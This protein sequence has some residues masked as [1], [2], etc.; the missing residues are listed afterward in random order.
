MIGIYSIYSKSQNKY[1]IGK[2]VD[3]HARIQKHLND[4]KLGKHHSPYLQNVYNKYGP[5]DLHFNVIEECSL[6]FLSEKEKKY[7]QSYD[8]FKN[9]FNCT[10]GGEGTLGRVF[11]EETRRKLSENVRGE[12]NSQY[13]HW[14]DL[15]PN[16]KITKE[17]ASYIWFYTHNKYF[18][19]PKITR[20]Q[21]I[22]NFGITLDI[23]KKIQQDKTWKQLQDEID[24]ED[25]EM[26]KKTLEFVK[27]ILSQAAN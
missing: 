10:L 4:L 27:L 12:R 19:F 18:S 3:I 17:I 16:S 21:W 11:S 23:Y 24:L 7:I 2:S 8:S 5:E 14:G 6:D 25:I 1:Y 26:Y 9:G 15:N 13:G 22:G 20:K